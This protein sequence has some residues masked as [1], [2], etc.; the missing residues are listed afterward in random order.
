MIR[1]SVKLEIKSEIFKHVYEEEEGIPLFKTYIAGNWK[2]SEE[3]FE[4]KSPINL[5]TIA[6]VTRL[7]EEEV[8]KAIEIAY[9]KGRWVIRDTPGEKRL[10]I[11]NKVADLL[12]EYRED[13]VNVLVL[14]NGKTRAAANGEINASIERLRRTDMDV[15][16]MYGEYVP[17]DW[18]SESLE[19]EAIVRR[20]PY[21]VVLAITPFNYPLF[22]AVN[23]LA[24][25]AVS[26]NALLLKPSLS[27]PLPALMLARILELAGF[28]KEAFSVLP[29]SGSEIERY[30]SDRRI[31]VISLTGSSET[32]E[33]V[34]KKS[35][36]KSFIMELGGGDPAIV[37]EDADAVY[38]ASRI[39]LG[40]TSY[41]GQRCDSIKLILAESPIYEQLKLNLIEELKKVKIG[42]PRD[43]TVSM[44]PLISED[45]AIELMK[46]IE[47]AVSKGG[48]LLFGG[49]RDKNYIKPTLIEATQENV[50]NM[51]LYNKEVF[52]SVALI[53]EIKDLEQAIELSNG[54]RYG[55]DA[56]I[57]GNDI[58]KIRKLI[59]HLEVGTIYIN[60]YPRHGI[61]Y[62]PFG[63]RK[64]SGIGREGIGYAIEYV[65]TYKTVVYSYKGKGIWEYL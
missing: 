43:P 19:S 64:D 61:G 54:R 37:L 42:D 40:I 32:G 48:K 34:I 58:N 49:E 45:T 26:A 47:D 23:K 18:S 17:G 29:L 31:A 27:T 39:A 20:E 12:E 22:D 4:V 6:R 46:G 50:R 3:F 24:Y 62:F 25:S 13:F 53:V 38:A 30:L 16:R 56:A 59:R 65:M 63:G 7:K 9:N 28:P 35:G 14:G 44:G 51:Y 1:D 10:R 55:L 52:A 33:K 21:G 15:R 57:F 36:I 41:S 11:F 60:D 2:A 5:S 8:N